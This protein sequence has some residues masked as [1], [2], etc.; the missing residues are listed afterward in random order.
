MTDTPC[1]PTSAYDMLSEAERGVLEEYVSY[2][3]AEQ[4]RKHQRVDLALNL[5]V[6]AEFM[7]KGREC[8]TKPVVLAALRERLLEESARRDISP[9][10]VIREYG[11]IAFSDISEYLEQGAWGHL[12]LKDFSGI[13]A[14]KLG[15]IKSVETRTSSTG[16]T[17][18][19]LVLHD[20]FPALKALAEL[21][22]LAA[23]DTPPALEGYVKQE[24][25]RLSDTQALQAPEAEYEELL[26][27]VNR[28][29]K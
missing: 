3:V 26:E 1:Y 27:E 19:K 11:K 6:P 28:E 12:Q 2:A 14:D 22:G 24:I 21:M 9:D 20:K 7:R 4:Q 17:Q 5:P 25:Q 10:R 18:V 15:A 29:D 16:A 13:P 8:F 23:P